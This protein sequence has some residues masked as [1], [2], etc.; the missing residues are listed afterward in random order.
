MFVFVII[1]AHP[2]ADLKKKSIT[3]LTGNFVG[4]YVQLKLKFDKK[5][6]GKN[7]LVLW[8]ALVDTSY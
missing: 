5:F 2:V 4:T 3:L 8:L 7:P 6:S 1:L